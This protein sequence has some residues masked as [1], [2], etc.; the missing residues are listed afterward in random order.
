MKRKNGGLGMVAAAI[1]V[2]AGLTGCAPSV[3]MKRMIQLKYT[4]TLADGSVFDTTEGRT[5]PEFIVGSGFMLP[6]LEKALIGMKVGE[7]KHIV[8]KAADAFGE[9]DPAIIEEVP[10]ASFPPEV[11]FRRGLTVQTISPA[12]PTLATI[13]EVRPTTVIVDYNHPLAGKDL[14]FDVEVLAIRS[15]T[16]EE[17]TGSSSPQASPALP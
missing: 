10:K 3:A 5:P 1:I 14:T 12:G 11:K 16:A 17:A 15:P 13:T 8:I 4:G 6:A 7:K 9:Y 2:V